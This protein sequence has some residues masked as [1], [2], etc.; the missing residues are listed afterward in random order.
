M[1]E[2]RNHLDK[3]TSP[4]LLQHADNP[5]HW[6]P[7]SEE[8]LE[9][10][11]QE[12]KPILLSIG[13][14]ACHWCHVMAHESFENAATAQVM[15]EHFINIKVDREERPDLD[16]LY[17]TAHSLITQRNGG[18]PL[19][20]FLTP[21][22]QLP[23]FGG[24]YF[25]DQPRH[26][27]PAFKEL[28][29][30]VSA[31]FRQHRSE[32]E[33]QNQQ[34][35]DTFE[36]IYQGNNHETTPDSSILDA[37]RMELARDFDQRHGG[38]G[39]APK[40]PHVGALE[41]L[42]RHWA[43]TR[44][45]SEEDHQALH[46]VQFTLRKMSEG[47]V[48]DHL[49]GGFCRYS[50]DD[51]W[52]IPHFE[53]MLYD[54]G[55]LLGLLSELQA[56]TGDDLFARTARKL[57]GWVI[58]EMQSPA[59]G[60]YCALDA[61]SEGEEGRFYY[62][63]PEDVA[64]IIGPQTYPL[65]AAR[66]GLDRQANFE[67]KWHLHTYTSI[68]ELGQTFSLSEYDVLQ[69]IESAEKKLFEE[70]EQRTRPGLDDKILTSWNALMIK[71]MLQA[72]RHLQAPEF[73][74]SALRALDFIQETMWV[75]GRLKAACKGERVHLNAYL[76]DYAFMIEAL[77][78]SLQWQ[79]NPHHLEFAR[80]LA[81]TLLG[82][83]RSEQGGFYFTSDDHEQLIERPRSFGDEAM[84]SGNAIAARA[85]LRLG[86]LLGDTRYLDAAESTLRAGAQLMQQAPGGHACLANALE[87]QLYPPTLLV[88]RGEPETIKS[89]KTE[90]DAR[91]S[92]RLLLFAI[93]D[94][95]SELPEGLAEKKP[96]GEITAYICEGLSCRPPVTDSTELSDFIREHSI[97]VD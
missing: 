38:L 57:A 93:P 29:V 36:R 27:L 83:F 6:Y 47:G 30:Q 28:L 37:A 67:G 43:T 54:N 91:Y 1:K 3:E 56:A 14:S 49:G 59:G 42:L 70:R 17:Q 60:Y 95:D 66:Y 65:F 76:D 16:K 77:L 23:F 85:L 5:V 32:I 68:E 82:H 86:Y 15:N 25:P 31:Y 84:P 62:W 55:P 19:T 81:D 79:W 72:A 18:W 45:I 39:Q 24:T 48:F 8:A 4:Y 22:N 78:E 35:A 90:L 51:Q 44:L 11:K 61:D 34:L 69:Q 63:E 94:N 97:G 64:M 46:I 10:A 50:V 96:L 7:W 74:G 58:R 87:E 9:L 41:R 75:D 21:D 52:M 13:Y 89:L 73:A 12:N 71:S 2:A 40:F 33:Q 80:D 88:V 20:M 26:G 92:P 53:K